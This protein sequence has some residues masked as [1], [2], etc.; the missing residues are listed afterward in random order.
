MYSSIACVM[1]PIF[2]A[3]G[4][5]ASLPRVSAYHHAGFHQLYSLILQ[6][7]I[8]LALQG[9]APVLSVVLSHLTS[10]DGLCSPEQDHFGRG[11]SAN[12]YAAVQHLES[13]VKTF[14]LDTA[15]VE[16]SLEHFL[17]MHCHLMHHSPI[18][19]VMTQQVLV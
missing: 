12:R 1:T 19:H 7:F 9:A 18:L 14:C 16:D 15:P 11:R 8:S 13:K 5:M 10:L 3:Y 2:P 17:T 4:C 6:H